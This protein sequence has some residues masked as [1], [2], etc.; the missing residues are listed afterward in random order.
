MWRSAGQSI[1]SDGWRCWPTPSVSGSLEP[2]LPLRPAERSNA[3][4]RISSRQSVAKQIEAAMAAEIPAHAQIDDLP[5]IFD[6]SNCYVLAEQVAQKKRSNKQSWIYSHGYCLRRIEQGKLDKDP[7]WCCKIC[8]S[9]KSVQI[10][11]AGSTSSSQKHLRR[12]VIICYYSSP[13]N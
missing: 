5:M 3:F 1:H 2:Q 10:L 6:A 7:W 11:N 8:S 9:R 4:S 12:S 13:S